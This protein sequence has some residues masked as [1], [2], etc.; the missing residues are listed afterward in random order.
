MAAK[1]NQ[2]SG[3]LFLWGRAFYHLPPRRFWIRAEDNAWERDFDSRWGNRNFRGYLKNV[4]EI[5]IPERLCLVELSSI[6]F[7][8]CFPF[9]PLNKKFSRWWGRG[10][11]NETK[12]K[13]NMQSFRWFL[14]FVLVYDFF[15]KDYN[16]VYKIFQWSLGPS[17]EQ[18]VWMDIKETALEG[19][20]T[21]FSVQLKVW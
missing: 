17:A 7:I 12:P 10:V 15:C 20:R 9:L 1:P 8:K 2:G 16:Y 11:G 14:R 18:V 4:N 6:A 21:G 5:D 3:S 13:D 19:D